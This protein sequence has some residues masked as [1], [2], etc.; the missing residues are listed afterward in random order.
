MEPTGKRVPATLDG[1]YE[2]VGSGLVVAGMLLLIV[3]KYIGL[4]VRTVWETK[5]RRLPPGVRFEPVRGRASLE[6]SARRLPKPS[7][8]PHACA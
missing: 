1:R 2:R 6:S 4:L 3:V 7:L 5:G 8:Q